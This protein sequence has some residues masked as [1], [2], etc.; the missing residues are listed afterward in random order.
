MGKV[1]LVVVAAV[2]CVTAYVLFKTGITTT[3]E[4]HF[5]GTCQ[6]SGSVPAAEDIVV[7]AA[8]GLAYLSSFN[9]ASAGIYT[10]DLTDPQS[11]TKPLQLDQPDDFLPLGIAGYPIEGPF[12][13]LYVI[14]R[15]ALPAIEVFSLPDGQ[16]IDTLAHEL[17]RYPN[18]LVATAPDEIYVTNTHA[19]EPNSL[20]RWLATL[21][22]LETGY[23]VRFADSLANVAAEEIGYANGIAASADGRQVHVGS[24]ATHEIHTFAR[25][26]SGALTLRNSTATPGGVDNI[27]VVENGDLIAALHPKAFAALAHLAGSSPHAPSRVVRVSDDRV[28]TVYEDTG[29]QIA[30]AAVGAIWGNQLLIGPVRDDHFLRCVF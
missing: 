11:T 16:H 30:A 17:L 4:P 15:A 8:E 3:I 12:E 26:P 29:E 5:E 20:K 2:V 13:R 28:S 19:S 23:V 7:D 21:F 1:L 22:R 25:D 9:K 6:A 18:N 27:S 10:L 24:I 14:N